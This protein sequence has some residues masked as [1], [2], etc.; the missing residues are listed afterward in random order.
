M[1]VERTK[2]ENRRIGFPSPE[3]R[4]ELLESV[5]SSMLTGTDKTRFDALIAKMDRMDIDFPDRETVNTR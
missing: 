3:E 5:I 4:L 2:G 1:R